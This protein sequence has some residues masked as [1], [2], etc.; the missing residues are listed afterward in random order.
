MCIPCPLLS[1]Q[2]P[3][4]APPAVA[5]M[6]RVVHVHFCSAS[7]CPAAV[8]HSVEKTTEMQTSSLYFPFKIG[9]H[10][11]QTLRRRPALQQIAPPWRSQG[12]VNN[13]IAAVEKCHWQLEKSKKFH[14]LNTEFSPEKKPQRKNPVVCCPLTKGS[15]PWNF[16]GCGRQ[17]VGKWQHLSPSYFPSQKETP[18]LLLLPTDAYCGERGAGG[19][20]VKNPFILFRVSA[21][22]FVVLWPR[23]CHVQDCCMAPAPISHDGVKACSAA[24]FSH[25]ATGLLMSASDIVLCSHRQWFQWKQW[26]RC[27]QSQGETCGSNNSITQ[28]Q[29]WSVLPGSSC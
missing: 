8:Q 15:M 18:Q 24:P 26:L 27:I 16:A 21:L 3:P 5:T 1:P 29:E 6:S 7:C 23:A 19:K 2:G 13:I 9:L 20:K 17:G 25:A 10:F 28:G 14:T 4:C 12:Q 11:P 22:G